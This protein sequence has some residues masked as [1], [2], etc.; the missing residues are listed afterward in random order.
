MHN[1]MINISGRCK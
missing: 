1:K